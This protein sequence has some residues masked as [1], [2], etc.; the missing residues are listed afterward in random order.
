MA[1]EHVYPL[2]P[3]PG[4]WISRAPCRGAYGVHFTEVGAS[5][6]KAKELCRSCPFTTECL[7]YALENREKYGIWG[8]LTEKERRGL[9]PL[10]PSKVEH[11]P[12]PHGT[13]AGYQ[14]HRRNNDTACVPCRM[15]HNDTN[16]RRA[17]G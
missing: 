4:D 5:S 8:G 1:R 16:R 11:R 13:E 9:T 15:A 17:T 3:S 10:V 2:R 12:F 14:Q 7:R 6:R